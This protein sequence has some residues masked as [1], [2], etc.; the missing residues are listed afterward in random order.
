[1]M[2]IFIL[3][4][5]LQSGPAIVLDEAYR[6]RTFDLQGACELYAKTQLKE[7]HDY[8]CAPW[9]EAEL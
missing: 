9:P 5:M 8:F 3:I 6:L 2:E 1:M 7:P 4:V